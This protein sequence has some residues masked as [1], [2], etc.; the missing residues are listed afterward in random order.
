MRTVFLQVFA[1]AFLCNAAMA[2]GATPL[3]LPVDRPVDFA[4]DIHPVLAE[5]CYKCHA[6]EKRRGGLQVSSREALLE[7]GET[8]PAIVPGDSAKS[9][10]IQLVVGLEDG[11][12]MPPEGDPLPSEVI[13]LLRAWID[14]G[15]QWS[16]DIPDERAYQTPLAPREVALPAP[17]SGRNPIDQLLDAYY[18]ANEVTPPAAP[19][20][21]PIFL[22]RIYTDVIGLPPTVEQLDAFIA[23]GSRNR[24]TKVAD[25]LLND[26]QGYAEHWM[27]FWND[28][29]R[30]DFQG[31]GYIDGGR[32]QITQ[33]LYDSLYYNMPYDQFVLQLLSPTSANEG[34]IKGIKWRGSV[35][36]SQTTNLQ[37]AQNVSQLFMGVNLKCASCH[38]SFVNQWTL[39]E[40]YALAAVFT[41][42]PLEVVRC[43][44]GTGRMAK[45][46]F[47]FPELGTIDED[48][49]Q[50]GKQ[51]QLARLVTSEENGRF[52]R[53]IV[54]RMWA[55]YFG[56]GLVEP[57]DDL[58]QEPWNADILDWL[59]TD[60]AQNGF[61]LRRLMR[62][63]VTSEA[64]R[65]PIDH[66]FDP[67]EPYVFRGPLAK[68]LSAE[69]FVDAIYRSNGIWS[70]N[71]NFNPPRVAEAYQ[72]Q[73]RAWRAVSDAMTKILGRPDRAQVTLRREQFPTTL[74]ALELNNGDIFTALNAR[75]AEAYGDVATQE[76][77][78]LIDS[79]YRKTLLRLPTDDER[80]IARDV[81]GAPP[82]TE[83][84]ADLLWALWMLP[85]F[86]YIH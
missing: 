68:R 39:D 32:T 78:T 43:D 55:V 59:S 34:F 13:S 14:Q 61:D 7:G 76:P 17:E 41:D 74:Q 65:R 20:P 58:D 47:L 19:V 57:L 80:A 85:E 9:F 69:Q 67:K 30:N 10:L 24:L 86:Q 26:H 11:T 5:N 38:D 16:L 56:H 63:I 1:A 83:G 60:L 2:Q 71:N 15:A 29:L 73:V 18:A 62:H 49:G 28:A 77:D 51:A 8:K 82:K 25:A 33:W 64:Y 72:N 54:N 12:Q 81:V 35:N 23:D 37:A 42:E 36:A 45:A 44:S 21:D 75:A 53:T 31:T 46:R 70:T 52:A 3:P 79:I 27:T 4:T 6:G 48:R 22:R 84:I 66:E 50:R 40:A